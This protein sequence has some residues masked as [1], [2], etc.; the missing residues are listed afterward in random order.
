MRNYGGE[1][2]RWSINTPFRAVQVLLGGWITP[3]FDF[4]APP[5]LRK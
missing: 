3:G 2:F 1:W 5:L 4:P